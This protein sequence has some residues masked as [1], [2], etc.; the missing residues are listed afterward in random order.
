VKH[1]GTIDAREKHP[2]EGREK[3]IVF[4]AGSFDRFAQRW[5]RWAYPVQPLGFR[6]IP[7][8]S[9]VAKPMLCRIRDAWYLASA[10]LHL[11]VIELEECLLGAPGV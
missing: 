11:I 10:L 8:V 9:G 1:F 5:R 2:L 4:L 7:A 3:K 6:D